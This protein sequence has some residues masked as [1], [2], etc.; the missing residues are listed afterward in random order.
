M[1]GFLNIFTNVKKKSAP[2]GLA[3]R[4]MNYTDTF[5]RMCNQFFD[6]MVVLN[7]LKRQTKIKP[8]LELYRYRNDWYI[9]VFQVF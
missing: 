6:C 9:K 2:D 4:G 1:F 5:M 8:A 3:H 7:T